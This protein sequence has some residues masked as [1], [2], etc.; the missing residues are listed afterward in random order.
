M[1]ADDFV[2]AIQAVAPGPA[3]VSC[4]RLDYRRGKEADRTDDDRAA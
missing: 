2:L 3:S 4:T 1:T